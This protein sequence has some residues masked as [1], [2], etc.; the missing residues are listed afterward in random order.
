MKTKSL[1]LATLALAGPLA[2][3]LPCQGRAQANAESNPAPG[4]G[5][6]IGQRLLTSSPTVPPPGAVAAKDSAAFFF[7]GGTPR[8]F[9]EA[10]EKQFDAKWSDVADIPEE[11]REVRIPALR[12]NRESLEPILGRGRRG[13]G[14]RGRG[15]GGAEFEG[16]GFSVQTPLPPP[17]PLEALVALYNS[18]QVAKRELGLLRVEG[19]LARPSVVMFMSGGR[20]SRATENFQMKA[21]PLRGIPEQEWDKL[22]EVTMQEINMLAR[23]QG[24]EKRPEGSEIRVDLHRGVGLLIVLGPPS[25]LETVDSFVTAW[26]ANQQQAEAKHVLK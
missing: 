9:L 20:Q 7:P 24:V 16:G 22:A 18:L 26:H 14:F 19:D 11:M 5:T 17:S 12:L 25:I 13:A 3:A 15:G 2:L 1:L 10:V 4:A 8:Q 23:V 21:F 6:A